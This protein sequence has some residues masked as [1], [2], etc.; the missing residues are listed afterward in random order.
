MKKIVIGISGFIGSGKS[1]IAHIFESL[2]AYRIDADEVVDQIYQPNQPGYKKILEFF[3]EEY[4]KKNGEL[5]RKKLAK[6][7]FDDPKKLRIL[8]SLIHPLV[9]TEI[10]KIIDKCKNPFII[11]EA[12][13]FEKKQL[14]Q[15][16]S[17]IIW[18]E[19]PKNIL[20]QRVQQERAMDKKLFEKIIFYQK[21][22]EEIDYIIENS[23]T[24]D[25]LTE[26]VTKLFQKIKKSFIVEA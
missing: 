17:K 21:K 8:H 10:Q 13:Y 5:N 1:T 20:E 19:C 24:I 9:T 11:I 6:N 15:L 22:P 18:I 14:K 2:G 12:T 23:K 26:K 7:I 25:E 3:G 16:I 4:F